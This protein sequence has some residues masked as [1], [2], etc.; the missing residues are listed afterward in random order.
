MIYKD[1][2]SVIKAIPK[3]L[4][5]LDEDTE[6]LDSIDDRLTTYISNVLNI[7]DEHNKFEILG[8]FRFLDFVEKYD[9]NLSKF[10]KFVRFYEA[11][12]FASEE[13]QPQSFKLTP[14]QV[15]QFANILGFVK[16]NG[17]RLCQDALLYVPRKFSK[18]TSV[19]ALAIWD[20]MFGPANAQAYVAANSFNQASICFKIISDTLKPLDPKMQFFR[21]NRDKIY[22]KLP[23]KTSFIQCLSASPDKLDGLNASTIILDEYAAA[24]SAALRN[25]LTSSQGARKE[26]LIVTLTTA[27]TNLDGP[28]TA[29]DLPNYKKILEGVI[30]DDTVFASIFQPDDG[31]DYGDPKTWKKAQPHLGITVYPEKYENEWRQAC[32]SADKMTEF[33]TKMLNVNTLPVDKEWISRTTVE[34]S[35]VKFTSI[36]TD[37]KTFPTCKIGIDLSVKDDLSCVTYGLYDAINSEI[38]FYTDFYIPKNTLYSHPNSEMYIR[39]AEQ[40]YIHIC[41]EDVIDYQKIANDILSNSKYVKIDSIG[42]D[43]Y[44]S[45]DL[46]NFLRAQG[47]R[48][49]K[50]YKQTI[51]NFTTPVVVFE[52][53]IYEGRIHIANNPIIAWMIDNVIMEEDN[54][55]NRK[56]MKKT[57]NKKIDGVI[58]MLMSL[59]QFAGWKR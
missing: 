17:L 51:A 48:C 26:P 34:L 15:F 36:P 35:F 14:V 59:G 58:T 37:V 40:G 13:Q 56:P 30:E 44:R 18:T 52:S 53:M 21:R 29:V 25:V 57:A 20:L 5:K 22:S 39:W 7:P 12:E 55:K 19:A 54:M 11:L 16:D 23:G 1:K 27:S 38:T 33:R 42:Y 47:V 8:C 49:L 50:P 28:F 6:Y 10:K 2:E 9:F 43:A 24:T 41:G 45:V 32:R 46:V 4:L 3:Y 31:D